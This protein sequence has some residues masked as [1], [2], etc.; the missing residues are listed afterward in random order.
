MVTVLKFYF[1]GKAT[2]L[3]DVL[4][5]NFSVVLVTDLRGIMVRLGIQPKLRPNFG[6]YAL[7]SPLIDANTE[8][9]AG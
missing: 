3:C 7:E 2:R 6:V 8:E 5:Y 9:Y 1:S 4:L